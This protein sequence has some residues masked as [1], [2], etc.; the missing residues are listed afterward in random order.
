MDLIR[1]GNV[2]KFLK[3]FVIIIIILLLLLLFRA[4]GDYRISGFQSILSHDRFA[5]IHMD[6]DK[7]ID[8]RAPEWGSGVEDSFGPRRNTALITSFI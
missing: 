5:I 1:P 6:G 8:R 4:T 3:R 7:R 2:S